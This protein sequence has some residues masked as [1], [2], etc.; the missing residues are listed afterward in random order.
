[1]CL[2]GIVAGDGKMS[3]MK[4]VAISPCVCKPN[5]DSLMIVVNIFQKCTFT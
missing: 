2:K 5:T 3:E 4:C 1:M